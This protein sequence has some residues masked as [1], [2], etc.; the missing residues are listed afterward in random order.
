MRGAVARLTGVACVASMLSLVFTVPPAAAWVEENEFPLAVTFTDTPDDI[1]LGRD[2][3]VYVVSDTENSVSAFRLDPI[4]SSL[5]LVKTL[6]GAK[7]G[8]VRPKAVAFDGANRMYVI[9]AVGISVFPKDW[10][11][12]DLA[13]A[14]QAGNSDAGLSEPTDI[15]FD[16]L[17]RMYVV[18][19]A[20]T[21]GGAGSV[22]VFA[23][24]WGDVGGAPLAALSGPNTGLDYPVG[25][26][27]DKLG[28]MYV[29]NRQ[30]V[31]A[32][33]LGWLG[34]DMAP[35]ATLRG[36]ATRLSRPMAIAFDDQDY[37]VV[38]NRSGFPTGS[39]ELF[40]PDWARGNTGRP[41]SEAQMIA[42]SG[43][44]PT[45]SVTGLRTQLNAPVALMLSGDG[46]IIVGNQRTKAL[47]VYKPR[48]QMIAVEG[49]T[50]TFLNTRF[51]DFSASA[52][53]GLAVSTIVATP[54]ICRL[55]DGRPRTVELLNVGA[56]IVEVSQLGD[57]DWARAPVVKHT[58]TASP[59]PQ[60][61]T[62]ALPSSISLGGGGVDLTARASSGLPVYWSSST[63][64]VCQTLG[65]FGK[66]L[67]LFAVGTCAVAAHQPGNTNW[68]PAPSV[69]L[70]TRV[71]KPRS[72]ASN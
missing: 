47:S 33:P 62:W 39:I 43:I 48:L 17:D 16:S 25:I 3:L 71:T 15:A 18:S 14:R 2:G 52:S 38:A 29:A 32:Y 34:G 41:T 1:A 9:S 70:T 51:V 65:P 37:M 67:K 64:K 54:K 24:N 7:T 27:F 13:P 50:G 26:A 69:S 63:P 35:I 12:G 36:T 20:E 57:D 68:Q 6:K 28:F 49:T 5:T 45:A 72:A 19:G 31:T 46:R 61:I 59:S 44:P 11:G 55:V 21:R 30:T 66:R 23:D 42:T 22:T 4:T 56:C 10:P 60:T 58:I 8:L 53:S 40:P